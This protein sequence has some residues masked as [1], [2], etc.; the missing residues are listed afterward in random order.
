M[1]LR[2]FWNL[3][4]CMAAAGAAYLKEIASIILVSISLPLTVLP[5][6]TNMRRWRFL[7]AVTYFPVSFDVR[8]EHYPFYNISNIYKIHCQYAVICLFYLA[9]LWQS[10]FQP[11]I[12]VSPFGSR[13]CINHCELYCIPKVLC[14]TIQMRILQK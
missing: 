11:N 7:K 3:P 5:C 10:F 6:H 14:G 12:G 4:E 2:R 13:Q 9:Q 8:G 1:F